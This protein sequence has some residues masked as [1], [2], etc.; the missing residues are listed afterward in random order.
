MWVFLFF[1]SGFV[2]TTCSSTT[3]IMSASPP[4]V[5]VATTGP[6]SI[7]IVELAAIVLHSSVSISSSTAAATGA[8]VANEPGVV[9]IEC[10]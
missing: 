4:A 7:S 1:V 3:G 2:C 6:S 8:T 9:A 5:T 10:R